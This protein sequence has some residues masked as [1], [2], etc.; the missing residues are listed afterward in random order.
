MPAP[1]RRPHP[2]VRV[3]FV[4]APLAI[5]LGIVELA[6][7]A[8]DLG[9][10]GARLSRSRGFDPR[11]RYLVQDP[12]V[13][14][15]W[16]TQMF[17]D[18]RLEVVVPPRDG[19]RRVLL[20]GGSNTQAFPE[21]ILRDELAA[22]APGDDWEVVN[23][24]RKGYGSERV[25]ILLEQA[26]VLEPDVVVI[27]SG[28]NE[29]V[30]RGFA[31]ELVEDAEHPWLA[32][33]REAVLGLRSAQLLVDALSGPRT[34][35]V[36]EP[37]DIVS[38]QFEGLTLDRTRIFFE[39][40]EENLR[41]MV[42]AARRA[43]AQLVLC[44]VIG[45]MMFPP[46]VS[47]PD[48]DEDAQAVAAAYERALALVPARFKDSLRP[49]VFLL[50]QD[51]GLNVGDETRRE[52][53][54]ARRGVSVPPLWRPTGALADAPRTPGPRTPSVEGA[55]WPHPMFW[56]ARVDA[57]LATVSA[58]QAR[59]LDDGERAALGR[60]RE[61]YARVLDLCPE[62]PDTLYDLALCAWLLDGD[63]AR[64]A[65]G[66]VRAA[67]ADRAPRKGNAVTNGIVRRVAAEEGLAL[68]DAEAVFGARGPHGIVGY[69]T[70][71]DVCHLQPGALPV[72]MADMA[73]FLA[74]A[75]R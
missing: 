10:P 68:F 34:V 58:W 74:Q 25:A 27:Y 72:L 12:G 17:G 69:E 6:L 3:V 20:F 56:T 37:W 45:N 32:A 23:L 35:H 14:G 31:M 65:E 36:P 8:L 73:A 22:R 61:A 49:P 41:R 29:F 59:A 46:M 16:R 48:A 38:E 67:A 4:L 33:A 21:W 18:A 9:D 52:R 30:E 70:M 15:G 64:A 19:R 7:V 26:M 5:L 55:H 66:L 54:A 43:G 2:L 11:A 62:H 60:A 24:G 71:L 13:P 1:S 40:Y 57:L 44:T 39:Q 75:A 47:T 53:A 51:W 28:H 42:S 63:A 50:V